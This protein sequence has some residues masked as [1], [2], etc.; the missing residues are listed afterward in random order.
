MR[1]LTDEGHRR[2]L[3]GQLG[4]QGSDPLA[5]SAPRRGV[6]DDRERGLGDRLGEGLLAGDHVHRAHPPRHRGR[7]RGS[8]EGPG[9]REH[10]FPSRAS[11]WTLRAGCP[12]TRHRPPVRRVTHTHT[13]GCFGQP[14]ERLGIV[15]DAVLIHA[16]ARTAPPAC[17]RG[18][19]G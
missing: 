1:S 7:P 18:R 16:H 19:E 14:G 8:S 5:R 10:G 9:R 12:L 4:V 13:R 11:T 15:A 17:R 2:V 3:L 6:V